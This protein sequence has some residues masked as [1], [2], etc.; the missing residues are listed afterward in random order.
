MPAEGDGVWLWC[1][2]A[3]TEGEPTTGFELTD[4]LPAH[5]HF[6]AFNAKWYSYMTVYELRYQPIVN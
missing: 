2:A 4:E 6:G 5:G 3:N 1:R